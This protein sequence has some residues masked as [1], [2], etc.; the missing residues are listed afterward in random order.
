MIAALQ[1]QH[2]LLARGLTLSSQLPSIPMPL[3]EHTFGGLLSSDVVGCQ[4][5]VSSIPYI[6]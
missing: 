4:R 2:T 6:R 3:L 1:D 5:C